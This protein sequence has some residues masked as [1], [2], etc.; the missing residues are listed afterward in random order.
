MSNLSF[1]LYN[2]CKQ[3]SKY[4]NFDN[5]LPRIDI[6]FSNSPYNNGYTKDELDMRRKAEILKYKKNSDSTKKKQWGQIVRGNSNSQMGN[7]P[8]ITL[9]TIDYL[10]NYNTIIVKYPNLFNVTRTTKNIIDSN[11][12]SIINKNAY[13]INGSNG[14]YYI[15]F[16]RN[17]AYSDC[18]NENS[19]FVPTSSSDIPGPIINLI[20]DET[21][22][23][24]NYNKN[25]NSFSYDSNRNNKN[26][27]LLN[28]EQDIILIK[29]QNRK[30]FSLLITDLI[31]KSS[32]NFSLDIPISIFVIGTNLSSDYIKNP[33]KIP[34]L[35]INLIGL[36]FDVKYN[37]T[38]IIYQDNSIKPTIKLH[39]SNTI[40]F[41][42]RNNNG[43]DYYIPDS[44][45]T[46]NLITFDISFSN[47]LPSDYINR[48]N[49]NSTF[50]TVYNSITNEYEHSNTNLLPSDSY[51]VQ[52]YVGYLNISNINLI[53][54]PGYI[55]DFYLQINL[56]D[57]NFKNSTFNGD[58]Y[59]NGIQRTIGPYAIANVSN[60]NNISNNCILRNTYVPSYVPTPNPPV[61]PF[62]LKGV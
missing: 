51:V 4:Q 37:D 28:G 36:F 55:Y 41:D 61:S 32:Y 59:K 45:L 9:T 39:N 13:Q 60:T 24:Y 53:T 5:R 58:T 31:D 19:I 17:G 11:G 54:S 14:Y 35:D 22:P 57:I 62:G 44:N 34:N 26:L 3:K 12:K 56:S 50:N 46:P 23:L 18:V 43:I 15:N 7:Y 29:E 49:D 48:R 25:V 42:Y 21:I 38:S 1:S 27:W 10:G 52:S 8:N 33:L 20:N 30:L 2:I 40:N 47:S 16:I 6:D